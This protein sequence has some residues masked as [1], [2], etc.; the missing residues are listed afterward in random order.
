MKVI[1]TKDFYFDKDTALTIGNFDGLHIGHRKLIIKLLE[2]AA[3]DG[4]EPGVLTFSPHPARLF[5]P[6]AGFKTLF[7]PD[8]KI[9]AIRETGVAFCV[10]YPFDK[11]TAN[12]KAEDFLRDVIKT[13]LRGRLLV[14]GSEFRFGAGG[15]GDVSL[16]CKMAENYGFRLLVV[17]HTTGCND[18]KVSTTAIKDLILNKK[19]DLAKQYLGRPYCVTGCCLNKTL[20]VDAG[21]LLPPNGIYPVNIDAGNKTFETGVLIINGVIYLDPANAAA[22][23][24]SGRDGAID[25]GM[26]VVIEFI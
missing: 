1:K 24:L 5:S 21:K 12:L 14:V 6:D 4:V 25:A 13:R 18:Q 23:A 15:K 10:S 16:M 2:E 17:N 22:E 8:E 9:N 11:D 19:M 3:I 20:R 7:T 26:P